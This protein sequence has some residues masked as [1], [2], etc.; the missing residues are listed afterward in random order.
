MVEKC[1]RG[2]SY[3][4]LILHVDKWTKTPKVVNN[5]VVNEKMIKLFHRCSSKNK[6]ILAFFED[7][8][9]KIYVEGNSTW[10]RSG[11]SVLTSVG[12]A[13]KNYIVNAPEF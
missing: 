4:R 5:A 7:Q 1:R 12:T 11:P 9:S 2:K 3:R 13:L 8:D 6:E 10:N